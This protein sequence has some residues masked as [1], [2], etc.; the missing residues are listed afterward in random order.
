MRE[1]RRK[2][3][4]GTDDEDASRTCTVVLEIVV[5]FHFTGVQSR[6]RLPFMRRP[7]SRNWYDEAT[8]RERINSSSN[9]IDIKKLDENVHVFQVSF[10]TCEGMHLTEECT[11]QKEDKAVEQNKY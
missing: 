6:G 4:N 5:L 7:F 8:T 1:L 9:N 11:L 2:L 10:K 3:F